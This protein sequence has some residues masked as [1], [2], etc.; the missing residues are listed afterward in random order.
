MT[1]LFVMCFLMTSQPAFSELSTQIR[2]PV[3]KYRLKNGLTVLLNPDPQTTVASYYLGI[4]TGSRHEKPGITGISHIFEHLMFKGTK[5]FPKIDTTYRENGVTGLNAHTTRDYTGYFA[6]FPEDKLELVLDVESDRM[7]NLQFSKEDLKKEKQ[8]V[9]EERRLSIDNS[10]YGQLFEKAFELVFQKHPYRWPILGWSKDIAGYT[11]TDL[12]KWYDTYYSPG[13][14]VL[15]LSGRFSEEKAKKLIEKYFGPLPSKK[16]PKERAI[17]EPEQLQPRFAV[18][19]R[20]VPAHSILMLWRTPG[21]GSKEALALSA[22]SYILGAGESGRLYRQ[23]VRKQKLIQDISCSI[24]N[25][26]QGS[27]FFVTYT[28]PDPALEPRIKQEILKELEK[29][30]TEGV[31]R[32]ELEK[33]K[34]IQFNKVIDQLKK[35]GSRADRL[36]VNELR[37]GDYEKLYFNLDQ[38][39]TLSPDFIK[40][41][42]QKHLTANK[43]SYLKLK[44]KKGK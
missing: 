12:T 21:H 39:E 15:V 43:V 6:N 16:I 30:F 14:A 34:N 19:E 32:E 40:T 37:F 4:S 9:Q 44:P 24:L 11:I 8:V 18:L 22:V 5:K 31:S 20:N 23:L 10:P 1:S 2:I 38:L 26:L 41:T 35:S 42:A 28:L 25:L 27:L 13:N 33:V 29:V 17:T 36:A 3:T 7:V